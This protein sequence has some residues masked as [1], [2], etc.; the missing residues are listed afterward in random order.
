MSFIELQH[1]QKQYGQGQPVVDAINVSIERGEF[2]VLVGP[3]GSGKSTILRLIAGLESLTAGT[4]TIDGK[5]MHGV[6]P[7]DRHLSMVFQHYALYPHLT[8]EDNI[9][10]GLKRQGVAKEQQFTRL[11]QAAEMLGLTPY[12]QRKPKALSGGQRQRVALARAIVSDAPICLMDE[13][14]SNL[15]AQL[16]TQMRTEIKALQQKLGLTMIYVTHDQTEAMT[17]GDRIMVIDQGKVQQVGEPLAL[18]NEPANQFVASFIGAPTMNFISAVI[19]EHILQLASG[20]VLVLT[21]AQR[22]TLAQHSEVVV[23]VRPEH[24]VVGGPIKSVI[25]QVEQLGAETLVQL[26]VGQ[27]SWTAKWHGQQ[28]LTVGEA[29]TLDYTNAL[30]FDPC[31][32]QTIR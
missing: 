25:E 23:G 24:I 22:A 6:S 15:D 27:Q 28:A 21:P 31:T 2:F 13:P 32:Q 7:R 1:V 11:H 10:F 8:V 30:F 14:L 9:L 16:R 29:V 12:L 5:N 17:M 19:K 4:I 26:K 18:Y 20:D 3:S